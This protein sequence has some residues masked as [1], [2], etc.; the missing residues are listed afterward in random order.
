MHRFFSEGQGA[1]KCKQWINSR[2][3]IR[4]FLEKNVKNNVTKLAPSPQSSSPRG[5]RI[6]G[7][8]QTYLQSK[9]HDPPI[10][11]PHWHMHMC[12]GQTLQ[13]WLVVWNHGILLFH[14]LGIIIPTDE[15]IFFRGVGIPPTWLYCQSLVYHQRDYIASPWGM[16]RN[17]QSVNPFIS[18]SV[19][20]VTMGWMTT[21]MY[22]I[23]AVIR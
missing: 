12:H 5:L 13:Y 2:W 10:K 23:L 20:W 9:S 19:G 14:I 22:I 15:I 16:G 7:W 1:C 3:A 11:Q 18:H 6:R 8:D 17:S 21:I 4:R